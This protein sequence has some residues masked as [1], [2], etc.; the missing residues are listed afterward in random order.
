M[1]NTQKTTIIAALAIVA[2][3]VAAVVILAATWQIQST[4]IIA[5]LNLTVYS[6]ATLSKTVSAIDWGKIQPG[7]YAIINLWLKPTGTENSQLTMT[8]YNWNPASASTY[9]TLIWNYTGA[10]IPPGGVAVIQFKL[11]VNP[12]I[13][14]IT[15]FSFTMNLTATKV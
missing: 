3:V 7:N 15:T 4:G 2:I 5:T 12:N 6:D 10:T 13:Y 9:L 14:G 11:N 1:S 8:T